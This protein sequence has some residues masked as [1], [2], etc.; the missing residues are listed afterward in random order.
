MFFA[1]PWQSSKWLAI[2]NE[3][4][5]NYTSSHFPFQ[6]KVQPCVLPKVVPTVKIFLHQCLSRLFQRVVIVYK[7]YLL[8]NACIKCRLINKHCSGF[9]FLTQTIR[10]YTPLNY[11]C[12]HGSKGIIT[13]ETCTF[14]QLIHVNCLSPQNLLRCDHVY[15]FTFNRLLLCILEFRD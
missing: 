10:E 11:K 8:E 14:R 5:S 7:F 12:I 3:S 4:V 6:A 1:S 13:V 2:A 9:L 15:T